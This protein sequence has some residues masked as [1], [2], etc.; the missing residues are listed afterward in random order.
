MKTSLRN[1]YPSIF[2]LKEFLTASEC[3]FSDLLFVVE[4]KLFLSLRDLTQPHCTTHECMPLA[5]HE[6]PFIFP[7]EGPVSEVIFIRVSETWGH[8]P[9]CHVYL[10]VLM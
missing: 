6:M 1:K 2:V 3:L 7:E 10:G 4:N 9:Q 8:S 5:A